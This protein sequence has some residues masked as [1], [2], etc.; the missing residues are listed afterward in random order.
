MNKQRRK[1]IQEVYDAITEKVEELTMLMEE[2]Q[3]AYDNLPE[4][5]QNGERGEQMQSHIDNLES[6]ISDFESGADYMAEVLS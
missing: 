3:E 4:S 5:I 1:R 2:E 6:A